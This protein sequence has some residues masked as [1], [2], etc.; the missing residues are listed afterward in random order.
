MDAMIT[1]TGLVTVIGW[2]GA[3]SL[4]LAYG[5]VS[6]R[7]LAGDSVIFQVLNSAGALALGINTAYHAAWP[8]AVVNL[9]WIGIG[10]AALGRTRTRALEPQAA[11]S[12]R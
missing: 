6:C 9:V 2:L 5:L 10:L 4:V 12:D 8:S 11:V 1:M 7:R 3:A